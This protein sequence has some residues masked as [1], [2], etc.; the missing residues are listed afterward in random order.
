MKIL[1]M[2]WPLKY[3]SV[4]GC[5]GLRKADDGG[6]GGRQI[7]KQRPPCH[8]SRRKRNHENEFHPRNGMTGSMQEIHTARGLS[9]NPCL[10]R[11]IL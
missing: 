7:H 5:Y 8:T 1:V 4:M 6:D 9:R 3:V 10:E 11:V 2:K